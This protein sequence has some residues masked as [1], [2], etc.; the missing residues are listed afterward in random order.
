MQRQVEMTGNV[1]N[2]RTFRKQ[3]QRQEKEAKAA[4]NR[5]KFGRTK[6]EKLRDETNQDN[7]TRHIDGHLIDHSDVGDDERS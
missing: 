5:N 7:Q 4:E 6:A 1:V 2:L 3:K